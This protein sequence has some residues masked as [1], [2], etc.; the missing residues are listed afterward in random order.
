MDWAELSNWTEYT[1]LLI[2]LFAVSGPLTSLPV[3]L[4]LTAGRAESEKVRVAMVAVFTYVVTLIC[5]TY[6]G[7][8]ILHFFGISLAAFRIAGGLLL[9]LTALDMMR[10]DG[11]EQRIEKLKDSKSSIGVVPIAIPLMAGPGAISTIVIYANAHETIEHSLLV[12]LVIATVALLLYLN[13]RLAVAMGPLFGK[14][15]TTVMNRV[16]GL[17]VASI[18]IEFML[19]GI[20]EHF[21]K[22]GITVH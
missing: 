2:G 15:G 17:I 14:T 19:H 16:L 5:F 13:L 8:A 10:S 3:Y 4:A 18:A 22:L 1:K 20:A 11:D 12:S 21:P 9:L 7:G 6:L